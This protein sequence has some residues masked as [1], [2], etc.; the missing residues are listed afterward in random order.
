MKTI[1]ALIRG[2]FSSWA[3]VLVWLTTGSVLFAVLSSVPAL[4]TTAANRLT[5]LLNSIPSV[6]LG[7]LLAK[8]NVVMPISEFFQLLG[9]YLALRVVCVVIRLVKGIIPTLG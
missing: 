6:N 5:A 1:E 2:L 9:L 8:A 7:G 3:P 4:L